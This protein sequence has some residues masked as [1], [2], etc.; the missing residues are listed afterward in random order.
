M[1]VAKFYTQCN[2]QYTCSS[3]SSSSKTIEFSP[4]TSATDA[5]LYLLFLHNMRLQDFQITWWRFRR[6]QWQTF[7]ML[8]LLLEIDEEI[9]WLAVWYA[10]SEHTNVKRRMVCRQHVQ[11]TYYNLSS[12]YNNRFLSSF[13]F[14]KEHFAF[15]MIGLDKKAVTDQINYE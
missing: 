13:R 15:F 10:H 7:G 14:K 2:F 5:T 12:I 11:G 3:S 9:V 8:T 1:A 4:V 6:K